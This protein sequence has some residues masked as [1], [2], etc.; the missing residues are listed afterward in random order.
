MGSNLR[1]QRESL[2]AGIGPWNEPWSSV[3]SEE[4]T[5]EINNDSLSERR[6]SFERWSDLQFMNEMRGRLEED[7]DLPSE[8]PSEPDSELEPCPNNEPE[9][10]PSNEEDRRSL[11]SNRGLNRLIPEENWIELVQSIQSAA[12]RR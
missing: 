1:K 10:E 8:Y 3:S 12:I 6:L 5:H 7:Y 4:E 11:G 9:S 2:S